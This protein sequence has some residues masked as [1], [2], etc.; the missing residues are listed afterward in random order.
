M[1]GL[2]IGSG[3]GGRPLSCLGCMAFS[4][5]FSYSASW[6]G[7]RRFS[8]WVRNSVSKRPI[9]LTMDWRNRVG[10]KMYRQ[11]NNERFWPMTWI[12]FH[13]GNGG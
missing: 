4:P 11:Y 7:W 13:M 8:R 5:W 2:L 6:P 10:N 9:V 3:I 12:K 1:P